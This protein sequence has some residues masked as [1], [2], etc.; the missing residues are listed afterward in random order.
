M[1]FNAK[2]HDEITYVFEKLEMVKFT[3]WQTNQ[4]SNAHIHKTTL[5]FKTFQLTWV[6]LSSLFVVLICCLIN[7]DKSKS[8]SLLVHHFF[9]FHITKMH[10]VCV[11]EYVCFG[12]FEILFN[13]KMFSSSIW[14]QL[15]GELL[16]TILSALKCIKA[17]DMDMNSSS[18]WRKWTKFHS[19]KIEKIIVSE[20]SVHVFVGVCFIN[21]PPPVKILYAFQYIMNVCIHATNKLTIFH[22]SFS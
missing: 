9:R 14:C 3:S 12:T 10:F 2:L 21:W 20:I 19:I 16:K 22:H 8:P 11:L 13:F 6:K 18:D 17:C 15:D 1:N 5:S 4:K 7:C